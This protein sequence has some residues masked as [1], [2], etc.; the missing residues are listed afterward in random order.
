MLPAL[1]HVRDWIFDLDNTLY[2]ASCDLFAEIEARMGQYICRLLD[3]DP[4]EARRVQK[5]HFH[6]HGTSLSGLMTEH[7]VDPHHFL[8]FVHDIDL[9]P[10]VP[11]PDLPRL[12]ARL[13]GRKLIFTN[14]DIDYAGRVLEKLGLSDSFAGI[15]D[16]HAT[17]YHPKPHVRAYEG[18]CAAWEI[19][20][21]TALFAEDMARN[22]VPAK[23]A[24]MTTLW[25]DNGS[26]QG[27]V[28]DH[29]HIDYTTH[30]LVAWLRFVEES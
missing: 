1:A 19:D 8:N 10:L 17:A 16:I 14:G 28:A 24:G 6:A 4:Q 23:A 30:D 27:P 11:D 5:M 18:L 15:H 3:C 2:P 22:L 9:S 21:H 25:V 13:P 29:S 26:E 12:L 20:P 7:Q